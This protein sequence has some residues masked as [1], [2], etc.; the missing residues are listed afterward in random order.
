LRGLRRSYLRRRTSYAALCTALVSL[1]LAA[2]AGTSRNPLRFEYT[3]VLPG[4]GVGVAVGD[5]TGDGRKDIAYAG[6]NW[7][8]GGGLFVVAQQPDG[9]LAPPVRFDAH[10]GALELGDLN[11]DGRTDVAVGSD[12][13]IEYFLQRGGRLSGPRLIPNTRNALLVEIA[14]L[15]GDRRKDLV[16]SVNGGWIRLA[17]NTGHG[18]AISTLSGGRQRR[19][20]VDIEVGD[21]TGDGRTDIVAVWDPTFTVFRQRRNGRFQPV[22]Y[23]S[24]YN[25]QSVELA[26]VTGDGRNDVSLSVSRNSPAWIKVYEQNAAGGL[27]APASYDSF[28]IPDTLAA[29][30]LDGNSRIDLVT[31][32]PGWITLGVYLQALGG[33]MESEDLY[34][35]PYSGTDP[36]NLAVGDVTG[37]GRADI[38]IAVSPYG[39]LYLYRQLPRRPA[40]PVRYEIQRRTGQIVAGAQDIGLHCDDCSKEIALPFPVSFYGQRH[41]TVS[42]SSNGP[43]VFAGPK[44]SWADKCLP[45][46]LFEQALFPYWS[47][48]STE[49]A[50][51]GV[52]TRTLGS[53]PART[54][55]IEWRA[56]ALDQYFIN[57]EVLFQE[58][59]GLISVI[60]GTTEDGHT[61]TASAGIQY[62]QGN[63]TEFSCSRVE[64]F[65]EGLRLDY[66][67]TP[68]PA[69]PRAQ[70]GCKVPALVGKRLAS[71]R[72]AVRRAN[73]KLGRVSHARSGRSRGIV[74]AQRPRAGTVRPVGSRVRL[75][76]SRGRR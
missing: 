3:N 10:G 31:Y 61:L 36:R 41:T 19:L 55:V 1:V 67:P 72:R 45:S 70:P 74:L 5:L 6:F 69:P 53:P 50:D 29:A 38:V 71:A 40:T 21:V 12:R 25:I 49:R 27:K 59:S 64:P 35:A 68:N 73:C 23:S 4:E 8:L 30:D 22:Q 46:I 2:P 63:Y 47:D 58:G 17:R 62:D 51:R 48:L 57:F 39:G 26:D 13:G 75:V 14:D 34:A 44:D 18:F 60:Y 65:V 9:S 52:F 54:F 56:E 28:Q 7:E 43:L 24:F 11:R 37:D 66:V 42:V 15:N 32:H 33:T 76:V 16:Y 20:P